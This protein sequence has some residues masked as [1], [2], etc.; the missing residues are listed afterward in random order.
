[1]LHKNHGKNLTPAVLRRSYR[2]LG[3]SVLFFLLSL[4]LIGRWWWQSSHDSG[5]GKLSLTAGGYA[6]GPVSGDKPVVLVT[7]PEPAKLQ[8][9]SWPLR[10][11]VKVQGDCHD[12]YFTVLLYPE[13]RD[14]RQDPTGNVYNRAIA[15]ERD[16]PWHHTFATSSLFLTT[17]T[18]YLVRADQGAEGSWYNPY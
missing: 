16:K 10:Q 8:H 4:G 18:Y 6:P 15:C 12:Q 17:G 11:D 5:F 3:L 9:L 13:T 2:I 7:G 1:M 14:Y